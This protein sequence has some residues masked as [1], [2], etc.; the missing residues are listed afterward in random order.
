MTRR[1]CISPNKVD[2]L[3]ACDLV[4]ALAE[5]RTENER[6]VHASATDRMHTQRLPTHTGDDTSHAGGCAV[7]RQ[8]VARAECTAVDSLGTVT[9]A[10]STQR[11][12]HSMERSS[13]CTVAH[14]HIAAMTRLTYLL[15]ATML[16][17]AALRCS[18]SC[19]IEVMIRA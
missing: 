9:A 3:R 17:L 4:S 19:V 6:C 2:E 11:W 10:L 15:V 14:A 16:L 18:L 1:C 12:Y 8:S 7:D 13:Q 5:Q